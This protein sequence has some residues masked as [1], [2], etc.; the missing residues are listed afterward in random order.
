M[1]FDAI[2]FDF[3]GVLVDSFHI[4]Q[5]AFKKIMQDD[6]VDICKGG[7]SRYEKI[8][9]FYHMLHHTLP[10][11][12]V[13]KKITKDFSDLTKQKIIQAEL[14]DVMNIVFKLYGKMDLFIISG[15]PTKELRE[16]VEEKNIAKF[17]KGVYG[18]DK[19]KWEIILDIIKENK[20]SK[21]GVIFLGDEQNDK[22]NAQKA[23][24]PFVKVDETFDS[25]SFL[26]K[27]YKC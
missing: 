8:L 2:F 19:E 26:R 27:Y 13:V 11:E 4:K 21:D 10:S 5:E 9:F 17:F 3:D 20:Y 24:I 22:L 14:K 18:S 6:S 23:G 1:K 15:T 25:D 16:I 12:E 7:K